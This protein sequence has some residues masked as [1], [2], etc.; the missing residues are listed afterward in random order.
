MELTQRQRDNLQAIV[1]TFVPAADF[2]S[3]SQRGALDVIVEL[4]SANP[5][6][7]ERQQ[8]ARLPSLWDSRTFGLLAA[9]R[10][11]RFSTLDQAEREA[12]LLRLADSRLAPN[13]VIFQGLRQ[14]SLAGSWLA[15]GAEEPLRSL[16]GYDVSLAARADLTPRMLA[17]TTISA[18]QTLDCDVVVVGSGA[19]GGT[20]AGTLAEA[21]L[22]VIV[23]ER[24]DYYEG[25]DFTGREYDGLTRRYAGAPGA[26]AEGQVALVSGQGL[27]GGTV[28]NYSTCF[29]TPR[30][31]VRS[32]RAWARRSSPPT[33]T[34][35]RSMPSGSDSA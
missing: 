21:G 22:D 3:G 25:S 19:G 13:R 26:T 9:R 16:L 31:C 6:A 4:I 30:T 33:S 32:G 35:R 7:A 28:I 15:P 29:R 23:L 12:F 17:P 10:P 14:A 5:R 20:A 11:V 2:P 34:T 18:D 24:G 1:D 27:G 8:L